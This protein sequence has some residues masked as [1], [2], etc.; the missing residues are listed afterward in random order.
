MI[1]M[2]QKTRQPLARLDSQEQKIVA[3]RGRLVERGGHFRSSRG[4]P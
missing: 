2:L 1:S 4:V 3:Q